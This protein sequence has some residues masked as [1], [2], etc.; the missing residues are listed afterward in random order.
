MPKKKTYYM[1]YTASDNVTCQ[2]HDCARLSLAT[3]KN[4]LDPRS[5]EVRGPIFKDIGGFQWTKSG[6]LILSDDV[7]STPHRLIFAEGCSY[8]P[9]V[10]P[11]YMD[12]AESTDLLNW[13]VLP[14]RILTKP[15][16][17]SAFDSYVIEPGPPPVSLSNGDLL[18]LYN[19]AKRHNTTKPDYNRYYGLGWAVL[20]GKDPTRVV[21]RSTEPIL[22]PEEK[23]EI[24]DMSEGDQTPFAVFLDGAIEKLG[25]DTFRI[26]YGAAD[27]NIG[28]ATVKVS[29]L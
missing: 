13:N 22:I 28:A 1:M 9:W 6:A 5:W 23:W 7:E 15:N 20:S 2:P 26:Y 24:G 3:S 4:P 17:V 25:K 8:S 14:G 29:G 18:F 27:A 16:N 10:S 12:V 19:G 21:A 11:L